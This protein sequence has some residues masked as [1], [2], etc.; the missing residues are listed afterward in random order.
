M[1][2]CFRMKTRRELDALLGL[3][4]SR[5]P[6]PRVPS[7]R[8]PRRLRGSAPQLPRAD[9][10][11]ASES[12]SEEDQQQQHQEDEDEADGFRCRAGQG[13]PLSMQACRPLGIFVAV[14]AV[15]VAL[16]TL[17][18]LQLELREEGRVLAGRL[19]QVENAHVG[20]PS[21]LVRLRE[22][23]SLLQ[24]DAE[25]SAME[26]QA[27][28]ANISRS[29]SKVS[30]LSKEL[31]ELKVSVTA[32]ADLLSV[33]ATLKELRKSVASLGSSITSVQHDIQTLQKMTSPAALKIP[34]ASEKAINS[35][36]PPGL[37]WLVEQLNATL[38][39]DWPTHLINLVTAH[40]EAASSSSSLEDQLP[41]NLHAANSTQVVKT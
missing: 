6:R 34:V 16:G 26:K 27:T 9:E 32:A 25:H 18:C 28:Q 2:Q 31:I 4:A 11:S 21:E 12:S 1:G 7:V 14:A 3:A 8:R 13:C 38:G 41:P 22:G 30:A 33:P 17:L 19:L 36:L 29:L 37:L 20:I 35:T 39:P 15:V 5:R 23:L 10:R 24:K 40:G